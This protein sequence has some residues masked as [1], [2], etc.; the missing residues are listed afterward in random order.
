VFNAAS[1]GNKCQLPSQELFDKYVLYTTKNERCSILHEWLISFRV[2][3]MVGII[4]RQKSSYRVSRSALC[5]SG[6]WAD[7][8][9]YSL[10]D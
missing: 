3:L 6:M 2:R 4:L 8:N 9:I 5:R 7:N 1:S 10:V